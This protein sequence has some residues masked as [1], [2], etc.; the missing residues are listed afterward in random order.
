[1]SLNST[2]VKCVDTAS[3]ILLT[4]EV[5]F[6]RFIHSLFISLAS[7]MIYIGNLFQRI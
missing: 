7:M 1:M 3:S 2:P 6:K 4:V 5:E